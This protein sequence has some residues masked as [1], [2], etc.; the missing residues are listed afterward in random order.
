MVV[1]SGGIRWKL[2]PRTLP[3]FTIHFRFSHERHPLC[4]PY[5]LRGAKLELLQ[6]AYAAGKLDVAMSLAASLK[7][8]LSFERQLAEPAEQRSCLRT[9][10]FRSRNCLRRSPNGPA[11]LDDLQAGD[12]VR[13]R[14]SAACA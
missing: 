8:T 13:D 3:P 11:G 12:T 6:A 9:R 1:R 10:R 4:R 7:E 14:R 2:S 5:R